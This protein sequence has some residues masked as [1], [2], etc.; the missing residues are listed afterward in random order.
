[1]IVEVFQAVGSRGAARI[2]KRDTFFAYESN[3]VVQCGDF[4]C[5]DFRERQI[6]CIGTTV[7]CA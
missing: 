6:S 5:V 3:A 1:M 2:C 4:S 7:A